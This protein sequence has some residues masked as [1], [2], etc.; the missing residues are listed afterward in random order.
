MLTRSGIA[1][2]FAALLWAS[3]AAS[4]AEAAESGEKPR[5]AATGTNAPIASTAGSDRPVAKAPARPP[6][7]SSHWII[8][9]GVLAGMASPR[10]RRPQVPCPR[11]GVLAPS[12]EQVITPA[13]RE[14]PGVTERTISCARCPC[15]TTV[16]E[17]VNGG[18]TGR[19]F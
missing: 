9:A 14:A 8:M 15:E 7:S 5:R 11:C 13:R 2:L 17:L 16:T 18:P 10:L 12:R 3:L 4:L 19:D 6:G 1:A